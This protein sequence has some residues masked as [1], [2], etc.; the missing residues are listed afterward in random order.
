MKEDKDADQRQ[1]DKSQS[2]PDAVKILR[3]LGTDLGAHS[4]PGMHHQRDQDIGC[5]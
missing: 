4:R 1:G 2:D 3:E 5:L